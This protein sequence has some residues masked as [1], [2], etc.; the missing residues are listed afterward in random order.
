L[1][2]RNAPIADFLKPFVINIIRYLIGESL[3]SLNNISIYNRYIDRNE[4]FR[5]NDGSVKG[6]KVGD[7]VARY[8]HCPRI[9]RRDIGNFVPEPPHLLF[10]GIQIYIIPLDFDNA[11]CRDDFEFH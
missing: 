11:A 3:N 6:L 10:V 2:L 8:F 9:A 4:W 7:Y 5:N 1:K